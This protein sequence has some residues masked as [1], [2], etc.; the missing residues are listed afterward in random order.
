MEAKNVSL[1]VLGVVAILAVVG[2]VLMFSQAGATAR[3]SVMGA[4]LYGGAV[5]GEQFPY[6]E[7]RRIGGPS[8]ALVPEY[9]NEAQAWQTGTPYRTYA[10]APTNIPS[11][12]TGCGSTEQ[13]LGADRARPFMD[14]Y[15]VSC[16]RAEDVPGQLIGFCCPIPDYAKGVPQE[17]R[18]STWFT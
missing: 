1:V 7:D 3:V 8:D 14:R 6:L 2:L 12:F 4:K 9:G 11:Q 18:H 10:R 16:R 5:K 17:V 13:L 15:G